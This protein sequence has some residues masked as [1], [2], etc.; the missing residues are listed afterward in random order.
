MILVENGWLLVSSEDR[1][2]VLT[3]KCCIRA[4]S[5][6]TPNSTAEKI[7]KKNDKESRFKLS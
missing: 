5:R 6:P 3:K 4:I 2:R 1:L 7:K